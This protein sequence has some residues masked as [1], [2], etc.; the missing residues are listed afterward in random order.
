MRSLTKLP[1][2]ALELERQIQCRLM[3]QRTSFVRTAQV[4]LDETQIE[5]RRF[6]LL[7]ALHRMRPG[8]HAVK[9]K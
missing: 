9:H 4:L 6:G 7:R 8:L 2:D 3:L 5:S 1:A